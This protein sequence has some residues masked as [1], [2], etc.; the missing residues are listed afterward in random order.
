MNPRNVG[1]GRLG[2][3]LN[4]GSYVANTRCRVRTWLSIK[5]N[6]SRRKPNFSR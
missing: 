1:Q 6:A 3:D 4:I 5:Q 2:K